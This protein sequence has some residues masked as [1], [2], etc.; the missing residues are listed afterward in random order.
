MFE[1]V[2]VI[3]AKGHLLGR[4][5]S[6]VAKELL[7]G[8]KFVIVRAEELNISG[9]LKRNLGKYAS[10]RN[11]ISC[12]NPWRGGPWH[13]KSPSKMFWRSLRGMIPHKT[14]RGAAALARLKIFEGIPYP[15]SHQKR[16]VVPCAMTCVRLDKTRPR[17]VI[18]QLSHRVGWSKRDLIDNL[19]AKRQER[20]TQ[21]WNDKVNIFHFKPQLTPFSPRLLR[22]LEP[23][24]ST[25]Q[26]SRPSRL[27]WP[28]S[29][30]N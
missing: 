27:S 24:P 25:S 20:A 2:I 18:K 16:T 11:K 29:V 23:R 30:T 15:Y 3:D 1:K 8:Q 4:L 22:L 5:A 26:K 7:N 28:S 19:E 21:Y 6:V 12:S 9:P 13:Y 10:F 17:T 14:A